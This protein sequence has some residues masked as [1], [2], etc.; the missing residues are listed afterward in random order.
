MCRSCQKK[1]LGVFFDTNEFFTVERWTPESPEG[2]MR[3]LGCKLTTHLNKEAD[4]GKLIKQ[5]IIRRW[6]RDDRGLDTEWQ[7]VDA[8]RTG[9]PT[10]SG[11]VEDDVGYV[12]RTKALKRGLKVATRYE[13]RR[14]AALKARGFDELGLD[15]EVQEPQM[16]KR[17]SPQIDRDVKDKKP[18]KW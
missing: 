9:Q 16:N 4:H 10:P 1:R 17:Y 8:K 11:Y 12:L 14:L 2:T 5:D 18:S 7:V 13:T 6:L 3:C 15:Y